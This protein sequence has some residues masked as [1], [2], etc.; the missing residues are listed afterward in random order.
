MCSLFGTVAKNLG[1]IG[2][3]KNC[4]DAFKRN[5]Y[6]PYISFCMTLIFTW[7]WYI[8]IIFDCVYDFMICAYLYEVIVYE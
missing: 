4:F 8:D 3:G 7:S 5:A 6:V 1:F 2:I